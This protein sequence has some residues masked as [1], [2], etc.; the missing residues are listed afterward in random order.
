MPPA[1]PS[2]PSMK[3]YRLVIHAT[4]SASSTIANG[5]IGDSTCQ[6]ST[7]AA[8]RWA[9]SRAIVGMPYRS[10]RN[11]KPASAAASA[12]GSHSS[13]APKPS[14]AAAPAATARPP[15]RGTARSCSERAFGWSSAKRAK[16][17]SRTR[18]ASQAMTNESAADAASIV[19]ILALGLGMTFY[20]E[21]ELDRYLREEFFG[22]AARGVM[23]EV[24]A[25]GPK[26]LSMS[27]HFRE[28]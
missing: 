6:T 20:A 24:G 26:Y 10:S 17:E 19:A 3:L 5:C 1:R 14:A 22:D 15:L 8:A 18:A 28:S 13:A 2:E 27:R 4:A 12:S 23:I 16:R 7:A 25:A 9:A 21:D 11:E